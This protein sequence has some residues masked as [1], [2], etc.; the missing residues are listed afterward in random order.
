MYF[1]D[2]EDPWTLKENFIRVFDFSGWSSAAV[3]AAEILLLLA[4][5]IAVFLQR[6]N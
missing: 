6:G 1:D 2:G 3:P 5:L 4:S